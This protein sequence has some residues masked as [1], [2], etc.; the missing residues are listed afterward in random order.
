MK[1]FVLV[2]FVLMMSLGFA[3]VSYAALIQYNSDIVLDDNG[4]PSLSD[5]LFFYRDLSRFSSMSYSDQL[6]SIGLLDTE[7]S[8]VGP[9]ANAWRLASVSDMS[10]LFDDF[11][12]VPDVFLPS[13][14]S[15]Y[16]GRFEDTPGAGAHYAYEVLVTGSSPPITKEI[17]EVSDSSAYPLMGAWAVASYSGLPVSEPGSLMLMVAGLAAIGFVRR[18]RHI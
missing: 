10:N 5:D 9:W 2:V 7:L 17:Y 6:T 12:T 11:V 8:G 4:T 14:G 13:F 16:T 1:R 15:G 3:S 18:K